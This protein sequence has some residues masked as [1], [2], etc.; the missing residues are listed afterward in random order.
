MTIEYIALRNLTSLEGTHIVDFTQE[1]LRSAGLFAI[2]GD[3][4]S[5]KSTLLDAICLALYNTAPRLEDTND[6]NVQ[7][8]PNH[9]ANNGLSPKDS[10]GILRKGAGEGWARVGFLAGDGQHYEAE[11]SV[12]T[13]RNGNLQKVERALSLISPK[14]Q[15]TVVASGISETKAA[16]ERVVGLDYEQFSRTVILAQNSFA[17]FLKAKSNEKSLLLEKL[18]GT[19]IYGKISQRIHELHA[20]AA[21]EVLSYEAKREGASQGRLPEAELREIEERKMLVEKDIDNTENGCRLVKESLK[22]HERHNEAERT[23]RDATSEQ[24][25]SRRALLAMR[26]EEIKLERYDAVQPFRTQFEQ[27]RA[28]QKQGAELKEKETELAR[29]ITNR[30][31]TLDALQQTLD[32]TRER[33]N[34]AEDQARLRAADIN[35]GHSIE[36]EI[37]SLTE[38]EKTADA[39]LEVALKKVAG[40]EDELKKRKD[41]DDRIKRQLETL[42]LRRQELDIHRGTFDRYQMVSERLGIFSDV[43]RKNK[44]LHAK[45]TEDAKRRTELQAQ[46]DEAKRTRNDLLDRRDALRSESITHQHHIEGLESS[47]LHR[48]HADA[49]NRQNLLKEAKRTWQHIV[50]G[51]E[52]IDNLR[53]DIERHMRKLEQYKKD[54]IR[55]EGEEISARER[56]FKL[57][58]NYR[59]MQATEIKELRRSL[60]EGMPCPVCG[61]A[62]HPY[63]TETEQFTNEK[64]TQLEREF[65]DAESKFHA[66]TEQRERLS[67]EISSREAQ[68]K[69]EKTSM[70]RLQ[71]QQSDL[72]RDWN[73]FA[74][75]DMSFKDCSPMVNRQARFTTID[76]L[77][78][79]V[80]QKVA[81]IEERIANFDKHTAQIN[82]IAKEIDTIEQNLIDQRARTDQLDVALKVCSEGLDRTHDEMVESDARRT[83]LYKDLDAILTLNGWQEGEI[84]EYAKHLA[85]LYNEWKTIDENITRG[86]HEQVLGYGKIE[87]LN[88]VLDTQR[89]DVN[90]R[91]EER[92][93]YRELISERN[94]RLR[95]LFGEATPSQLAEQLNA[96]V[97]EQTALFERAQDEFRKAQD[98]THRL[99]GQKANLRNEAL[100]NDEERRNM[101]LALDVAITQFNRDNAPLQM[102]ELEALF[103]EPRDWNA[104]R[105]RI[106]AAKNRLLLAG[107]NLE[108]A[109]QAYLALQAHAARISDASDAENPDAMSVEQLQARRAQLELAL[110]QRQEERA[111]LVRSLQRHED[112]LRNAANFEAQLQ[113]ARDNAEEWARLRELFGSADG[114][115]FRDLAQSYTFGLLVEHANH[116]LRRLTPRYRL[117]VIRDTLTLEVVD[118]DMLDERRYVHSLSGGETFIVSLALALGLASLSGTTL[119]IGSLFIDEG[120]GNLD[121]ESLNV[122][123]NTLSALEAVQGRKVGVVS[124]TEQIRTQISPQIRIERT[125]SAGTSRVKIF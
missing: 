105:T 70:E 58:Y 69:T 79:S 100:H 15:R 47:K 119:T 16:V 11:W 14:G 96:R 39:Q 25:E 18:T 106:E 7:N 26:G 62:H 87:H 10:R 124:H 103:T 98:E 46:Y 115:R 93:R 45:H 88:S 123:L 64:Q 99:E 52:Q 94:D 12:K 75:L 114:K 23:L 49:N 86:E 5:G 92:D 29:L 37:K 97:E 35:E 44:L 118:H 48:E 2:T 51:Y 83:Q 21:G 122:V 38:N 104:L 30:K 121:E 63:H 116:H 31:Q 72:E 67:L 120:F 91:R 77:L 112:S 1:P 40:S 22:W 36:G 80:Q 111:E 55:V 56:Y 109:Q 74:A 33:K 59:L 71:A 73:D 28:I 85:E 89:A 32:T 34:N 54:R 66:V 84:D 41:D 20:K 9:D 110:R 113:K 82:T 42:R 50:Q 6:R 76:M 78:D 108:N 57:E 101:T 13:S 17:N 68:L 61:S 60:H 102:Q 81:E 125:G 19:A 95:R 53:A 43:V 65:H 8:G 27:L 90:A 4:G 117:E 24:E 107:R 3:T